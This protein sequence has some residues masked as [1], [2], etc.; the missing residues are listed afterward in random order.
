[1]R[2]IDGVNDGQQIFSYDEAFKDKKTDEVKS[3]FTYQVPSLPAGTLMSEEIAKTMPVAFSYR[4]LKNGSVS[5]T[6]NTYLGRDYMGSAG[7]FGNHLSHSIICD[8]SDFDI[9]P[10]ELYASIALRNSMDYE[11]VN[12]PDPPKYLE[13]PELTKGYVINPESI[14]NGLIGQIF[15]G[16]PIADEILFRACLKTQNKQCF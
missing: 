9:Y 3:L 13:V 14:T 7:R 1:M 16:V 10:C 12:N 6:L 4:M 2:G 8:F 5:V 11:E 15:N